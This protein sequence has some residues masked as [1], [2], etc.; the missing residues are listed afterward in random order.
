MVM[1]LW[2]LVHPSVCVST[3]KKVHGFSFRF[4]FADI[5]TL[6]STDPTSPF[7]Q[8]HMG[9]M[10]QTHEYQHRRGTKKKEN[11][12][13]TTQYHNDAST[14]LHGTSLSRTQAQARHAPRSKGTRPTSA[15][16][17]GRASASL[18]TPPTT[19]FPLWSWLS[20]F[21]EAS[22]FWKKGKGKPLG[23][24]G[25]VRACVGVGGREAQR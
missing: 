21:S 7:S 8:S 23:R 16:V 12:S 6:P 9:W 24:V 15:S 2:V 11:G 1:I 13:L 22:A 5:D 3:G 18:R 17:K 4:M 14:H 19:L 10:Y 20:V 25:K